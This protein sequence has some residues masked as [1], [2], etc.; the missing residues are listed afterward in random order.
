MSSSLGKMIRVP[1]PK[2]PRTQII[3]FE[4]P[5]TSSIIAKDPMIWVLGPLGCKSINAGELVF[6]DVHFGR[7]TFDGSTTIRILPWCM[8]SSQ[9]LCF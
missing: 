4:G 2:G 5:N 1:V 6:H 9:N 8:K 7:R 3:G